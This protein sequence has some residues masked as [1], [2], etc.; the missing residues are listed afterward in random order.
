MAATAGGSIVPQYSILRP[1]LVGALDR[2]LATPILQHLRPCCGA[3]KALVEIAP[4]ARQPF[5]QAVDASSVHRICSVPNGIRHR[6]LQ[7]RYFN[8]PRAIKTSHDDP[9]TIEPLEAV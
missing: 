7:Q 9:M 1:F 4:L 2:F 6:L 5:G 8:C 3:H